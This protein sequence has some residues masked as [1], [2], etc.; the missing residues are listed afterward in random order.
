[1]I[2][3]F[4]KAYTYVDGFSFFGFSAVAIIS[5]IPLSKTALA[6][7]HA[8]LPNFWMGLY[9]IFFTIT[10]IIMEMLVA[11]NVSKRTRRESDNAALIYSKIPIVERQSRTP[12]A[13]CVSIF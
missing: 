5:A 7:H 9:L 3:A 2:S 4:F 6:Q 11:R 13:V 1:M 12:R 10:T 8:K